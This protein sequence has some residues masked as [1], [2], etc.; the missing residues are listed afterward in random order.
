MAPIEPS[1]NAPQQK[2][3]CMPLSNRAVTEQFPTC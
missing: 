3:N 2:V 1:V